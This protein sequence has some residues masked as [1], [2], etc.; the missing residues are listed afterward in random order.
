MDPITVPSVGPGQL[1]PARYTRI[2]VG[3]KGRATGHCAAKA[4]CCASLAS[5]ALLIPATYTWQSVQSLSLQKTSRST[6]LKK[7]GFRARLFPP[8]SAA[9]TTQHPD[10]DVCIGERIWPPDCNPCRVQVVGALVRTYGASPYN[11]SFA[12]GGCCSTLHDDTSSDTS[13]TTSKTSPPPTLRPRAQA[14][15]R[16]PLPLTL[17]RLNSRRYRPPRVRRSRQAAA[18]RGGG[19]STLRSLVPCS[20]CASPRAA[21]SSSSL[22]ARP[23]SCSIHGASSSVPHSECDCEPVC[24]GE[25]TALRAPASACSTGRSRSPSSSS[26]LYSLSPSPTASCLATGPA[27][28]VVSPESGVPPK[29]PPLSPLPAP[30]I[31]LF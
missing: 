5:S 28:P 7:L 21:H 19:R 20:R 8:T 12:A 3:A 26:P 14:L 25:L 9:E 1:G 31:S 6:L 18:A 29:P 4:V 23:W 24:G 13:T 30:P 2:C 16:P 15:A 22:Y 11:I 10:W 27:H 17:A